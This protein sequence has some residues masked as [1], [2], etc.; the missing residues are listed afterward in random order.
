MSNKKKK[1]NEINIVFFPIHAFINDIIL[2]LI[3][4]LMKKEMKINEKFL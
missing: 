3:R 2:Y 4:K 1:G